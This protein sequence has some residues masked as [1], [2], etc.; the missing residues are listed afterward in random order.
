MLRILNVAL[1]FWKDIGIIN[2]ALAFVGR[3]YLEKEFMKFFC[4]VDLLSLVLK[5]YYPLALIKGKVYHLLMV[6]FD[7]HFFYFL[8]G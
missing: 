5:Y 3:C 7:Q 1:S 8:E 2:C 6:G 4:R